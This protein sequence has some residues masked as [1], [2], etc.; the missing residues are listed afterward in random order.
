MRPCRITETRSEASSTS[1]S[2]WVMKM[3]E[4]P[5]AA[6][7][8]IV[9]NSSRVSCGVSTAVGSSRMR[10]SAWRYRAL[11]ISTRCRNPTGRLPTMAF[12]VEIEPE[13]P[14]ELRR[15][16]FGGATIE[17]RERIAPAPRPK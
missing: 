15:L 16:P 10:T 2:L 9:P 7:D 3:T 1:R 14:A 4:R 8:R 6:S 13:A 12:R 5:L 11:R 17:P